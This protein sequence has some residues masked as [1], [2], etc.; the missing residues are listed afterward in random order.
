M[1]GVGVARPRPFGPSARVRGRLLALLL[2]VLARNGARGARAR[3]TALSRSVAPLLVPAA[4]ATALLL[5]VAAAV[6]AL[7]VLASPPAT[8]ALALTSA[9]ML[10]VSL[11]LWRYQIEAR[12]RA[13]QRALHRVY[14]APLARP[15]T[16]PRRTASP[17]PI[18]PAA[19]PRSAPR[20]ESPP[21]DASPPDH[22]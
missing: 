20:P 10:L 13:R 19:A 16:H 21:T 18:R 7:L 22:R 5:L 4:V 17:A 9:G 2:N 8:L 11:L 15:T 3:L 6:G 14:R 1:N 12:Q